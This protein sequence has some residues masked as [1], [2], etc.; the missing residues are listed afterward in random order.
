MPVETLPVVLPQEIIDIEEL[1]KRL[2]MTVQGIWGLTRTRR[3]RDNPLPVIRIGTALRFDWK[4]VQ[5]WLASC[6][7]A[8]PNPKPRR[9]KKSRK[10]SA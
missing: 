3:R 9:Y 10:K 2:Q 4:S 1:A 5:L 6:T 8:E 7:D